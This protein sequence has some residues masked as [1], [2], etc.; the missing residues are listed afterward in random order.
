MKNPSKSKDL[1]HLGIVAGMIDQL[2]IVSAI[3]SRVNQDI[4]DRHISIGVGIK[5]MIINGLGFSQR[6]LYMVSSYFEHLPTELLLGPGV[7]CSHLNDSVLGRILDDV[8]AYGCTKLYG[9]LAVE[10]CRSLN[11]APGV[12]CMDSTDFH[13]DGRYNS[14]IEMAENSKVLHLTRGYSRDHRP[15][16]N[17]VVLNLIVENQAGIAL[18]MEAHSGNKSDKTV[19]RETISAHIS[20]LQ[21]VYEVADLLMDSA[22]YTAENIGAHSNSVTWTS[23]VPESIKEARETIA[24][25][26]AMQDLGDGYRYRMTTSNYGGVAQ[27]WAV[28]HSAQAFQKELITLKKNYLKDSEKAVRAFTKICNQPFSCVGDAEKHLTTFK[29]K[30]P[31]IEIHDQQIE[32]VAQYKGKGRPA[33]Q[34][35]PSHYIYYIRGSYTCNMDHFDNLKDKK[36][37]FIIATN[38]LDTN[39]TPDDQ[40]LAKYKGLSKVEGGFRFLKDPQFIAASFFVKKPERVEALLFIMTLCLSI[41]AA[42]EYQARQE[43]IKTNQTLPNQ[44]KK[45]VKNPTARWLFQIMA[46]T[47][48]VY[49]DDNQSVT[50]NITETKQKVIDLLGTHVQK[51]YLR[52]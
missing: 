19:F 7:N 34:T 29:K 5:A 52:I 3:D 23:R 13:L 10:I 26:G 38:N 33:K 1:N 31:I 21:N 41:Y 9:E 46:G 15:D 22:G 49:C 12:L 4:T 45:Q 6:T 28:I 40:I 39:K 14:D 47:H 25:G 48:V 35:Q 11:L 51:Y 27:R 16:L 36:G 37:K 42:I 24:A 2:G 44:I 20:Q 18:H 43:L 8:H 32:S 17:Q 50:L 30:Y